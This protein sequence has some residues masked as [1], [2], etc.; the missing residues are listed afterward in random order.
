MQISPH[1]MQPKMLRGAG[2]QLHAG[3]MKK[4][5]K[6]APGP[7]KTQQP[8]CKDYLILNNTFSQDFINNNS[9][10]TKN[11]QNDPPVDIHTGNPPPLSYTQPT[12]KSEY[13]SI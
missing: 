8:S 12:S 7:V 13:L 1:V 4:G 5:I 10:H 9:K 11:K 6:T 3:R 2:C